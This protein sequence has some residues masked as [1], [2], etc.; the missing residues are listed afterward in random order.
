MG[1]TVPD[2]FCLLINVNKVSKLLVNQ[3]LVRANQESCYT[4]TDYI[5]Y[6]KVDMVY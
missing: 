6:K 2:G 4:W 1:N 3:T 5:Y